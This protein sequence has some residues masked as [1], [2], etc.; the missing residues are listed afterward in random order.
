MNFD[1]TLDDLKMKK[2][3][4]ARYIPVWKEQDMETVVTDETERKVLIYKV[5]I[6]NN[7]ESKSIVES[8]KESHKFDDLAFRG[9]IRNKKNV[10]IREI[11]ML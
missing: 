8:W 9:A 2:D 4:E 1:A 6:M 7:E 10:K 11:K 3:D 5:R